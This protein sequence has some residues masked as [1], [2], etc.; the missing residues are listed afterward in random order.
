MTTGA[1]AA[2]R[3]KNVR[4]APNSCS[5]PTPG[6]DAEQGE[7]GRL[8]PA[9]LVRVGDV[10]GERLGDLRP[11]RRLVVGLDEAAAPAD[12]LAERPEA[13][14]VAVGRGC[15]RRATRR[16]RPAP[17]MY[18]RNSQARRV[19]PIPAGPMT[20]TRRAR[21]SRPVAWNR[22]LSR[23][24]SSSRPTNGASSASERSAAADL[25]DD[26][27]RP[28]GRDRARLALEG[29]LA[30]GLEGDRPRPRPL[31]RLADEDRAR[32][33]RR[34]EPAGGVDEVAGDHA[35]VRRA[36][37]DRGLAGQDAGPGLDRRARARRTASTS[38]RAGPDGPLGVVLVGRRCAPDRHH[39]VADELL[40]RAAVAADDVPGEVEVAGQ[41][42]AGV[43]GVAS[44]G[45]RREADEVGEQDRDEAALGD[46]AR[47]RPGRAGAR[48][49]W[50]GG[51]IRGWRAPAASGVAHSP[52]N[53][54]VG[55][56]AA[57]Q[58]GQRR[59]VGAAHSTQNLRP[60]SFS[61]PQFEQITRRSD[62]T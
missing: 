19:L 39:R 14:P 53:F 51:G 25:G 23:R 15:G 62:A 45:E 50:P 41:E 16:S 33:G 21:F 34:L 13:D 4:Q 31:G 44:L 49:T 5:E 2:S 42:L 22:S 12:H 1:V 8:D 17:S 32:G 57:P 48:E 47:R 24:S 3:S 6:L 9:P 18:L 7:E 36:E 28:P 37:R 43:L 35:L 61:V 60:A 52:Q 11:G 30:G 54:A 55:A 27:E 29:L 59:R 26:P 46:G 40:D 10:L 56:F 58:A 38:S 20:E